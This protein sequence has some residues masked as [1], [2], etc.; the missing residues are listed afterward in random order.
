M[1][2]EEI[3]DRLK[4]EGGVSAEKRVKEY[5]ELKEEWGELPDSK[6]S[7]QYELRI[8]EII[9]EGRELVRE[10]IYDD[11][12]HKLENELEDYLWE[13]GYISK[14]QGGYITINKK[15]WDNLPGW[16]YCDWIEVEE[17]QVHNLEI[18]QLS[19][20]EDVDRV[21]LDNGDIYYIIQ[22]DY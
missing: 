6:D 2:E 8:D 11:T 12:Y 14:E 21:Y 20:Y 5:E 13:M 19:T 17:D 1:D 18:E 7:S 15:Q 22:I 10:I 9:E 3:I 16:V 4:Y